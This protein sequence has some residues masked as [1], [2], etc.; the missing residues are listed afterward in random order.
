MKRII[1]VILVLTF[2]ILLPSCNSHYQKSKEGLDYYIDTRNHGYS[3]SDFTISSGCLLPVEFLKK[4]SYL[5]GNY[6]YDEN[7]TTKFLFFTENEVDRA[8]IWLTYDV[9][10]YE[11]WKQE[12]LENRHS[13]NS[14]LDGKE[15]FGF[16]FYS[17][18]EW[19]QH[20]EYNRF[21]YHFTAFGVNDQTNTLV[22][23]G[24]YCNKQSD[25]EKLQSAKTDLE[26]F[27]QNYFGEWYN[28]EQ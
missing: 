22:F 8:F 4:Y 15:A 19:S 1:S 26:G 18:Y 23:I 6:Y 9:E 21:P 11:Q 24:F 5:D 28:W 17:N 25:E 2:L 12:C 20:N 10:I 13:Q 27:I 7:Y 16:T 3:D 14:D